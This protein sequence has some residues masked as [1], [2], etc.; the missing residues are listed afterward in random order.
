MQQSPWIFPEGQGWY[1]AK[2]LTFGVDKDS[3]AY[4]P[5]VKGAV[6]S[7]LARVALIPGAQELPKLPGWLFTPDHAPAVKDELIEAIT[8]LVEDVRTAE[9]STQGG[10]ADR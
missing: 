10:G 3:L 5:S 6:E 1:S 4:T 9:A 7:Y 8:Q 2:H